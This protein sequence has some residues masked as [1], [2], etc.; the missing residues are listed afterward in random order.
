MALT[1]GCDIYVAVN[2]HGINRVARDVMRQRPSLFNYASAG[3][4]QRPSLLCHDVDAHPVVTARGNPLMT[5]MPPLPVLAS[6]FAVDWS[7]Q[8]PRLEVDVHKGGTIGLPPELDPLAEQRIAVVAKAC[9]G[10]GCPGRDL[11][12]SIEVRHP[13]P[14]GVPGTTTHVPRQDPKQPPVVLPAKEL[15][16]FCIEAYVIGGVDLRNLGAGPV[17]QLIFDGLELV[18]LTPTGLEDAIECY[19]ELVVRL[20]LLPQL[21]LPVLQLQADLGL[22]ALEIHPTPESAAIPNNPALEEDQIKVR[23]DLVPSAGSGGGGGGG[24]GGGLPTSPRGA[25]RARTRTGPFDAQAGLS[26]RTIQELFGVVRDGFTLDESG[27]VTGVFTASYDVEAHLEHGTI[28][29]SSDGT[30]SLS[31]LDVVWDHLGVALGIDIPE[32]CVGGW[33]IVPTPW[34]CAVRLPRICAFSAVPDLGIGFDLGGLI[35]SEI[36]ARL[37]PVLLYRRDPARAAWMNDWDARDAGVPDH[38]QLFVDIVT[39]D[40]DLIDFADTI[41]DLIEQ[42][43]ED[44]I[45]ALLGPFAGWVVD[46]IMAIL[47]PIIDLV[48]DILDI[49]DDIE[50]WLSNLLGVSF[51]LFDLLL[52]A[53]GNWFLDDHPLLEIENPVTVLAEEPGKVAVLLPIDFIDLRVEDD[54][55][56]LDVDLGE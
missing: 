20:G 5:V 36:S 40:L 55:I 37:R 46:L 10:L 24:G 54:E 7:V 38:W 35:R 33:C 12:G 13:T 21:Q 18:D 52:T 32:V 56:A 25:P 31:E 11:P 23:I 9:A 48:R 27:G 26:E 16:C 28:D 29:L 41:G 17:P 49:G 50:E 30:I 19:A 42:A 34:G 44:A 14:A 8:L 4:A 53:V 47:G 45:E 3:I 15:E 43:I 22:I 51:G 6:N 1:D 2:E 39:I